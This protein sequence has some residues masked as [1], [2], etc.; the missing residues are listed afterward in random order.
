MG[1]R[2]AP[3]SCSQPT[4]TCRVLRA[5]LTL[6]RSR[7]GS[8]SWITARGG[9]PEAHI[10]LLF[11]GA[12]ASGAMTWGAREEKV[13]R[14]TEQ[15]PSSQHAECPRGAIRTVEALHLTRVALANAGDLFLHLGHLLP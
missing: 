5:L 1:A 7:E 13:H 8:G 4:E 6:Q 3:V 14:G 10:V 15:Q 11:P 12:S 2:C 9:P